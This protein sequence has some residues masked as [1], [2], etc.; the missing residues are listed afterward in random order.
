M[1]VLFVDKRILVGLVIAAAML[2]YIGTTMFYNTG[3]GTTDLSID[4]KDTNQYQINYMLRSVRSFDYLDCEYVLLDDAGK[5]VGRANTIFKDIKDGSFT[6]NQSVN[7]TQKPKQLQIKI[8]T[9]QFN[10]ELKNSDG[11]S[12]QNPFFE[13]K[14]DI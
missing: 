14:T 7:T 6:V 11:T 8:Y 9:E 3:L 1:E 5:E 12:A 2:M 4:E 13:Q 10:P